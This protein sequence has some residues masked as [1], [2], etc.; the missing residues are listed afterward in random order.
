M[1]VDIMNVRGGGYIPEV[2]E[3]AEETTTPHTA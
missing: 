1:S 3:R 2:G